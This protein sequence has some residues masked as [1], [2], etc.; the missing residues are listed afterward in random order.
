LRE[1]LR[2]GL[3]A[4]GFE[5]IDGDRWVPLG[6]SPLFNGTTAYSGRVTALAAHPTDP[7]IVYVGGAQGGVWKTSDGGQSWSPLTDGED[8]L[9]IGALALDPSDPDTIYAGTGEPNHSCGSYSGAGILRS[10]DAGT[11]WT[12]IGQTPFADTSIAKIVVHPSIPTILWAANTWGTGGFGCTVQSGSYGVWQSVDGGAN[13]TLVLGAGQTFTDGST[14]ELIISPSDPNRLWAGV[15]RSGLWTS[16]NG[17]TTWTRIAGG[18]PSANIG[19]I[20][21]AVHPANASILYAGFENRS[22]GSYLGTW[23]STD[24]GSSWTAMGEPG[25]VSCMGFDLPDVCGTLCGYTLP[26]ELDPDGDLWLG[27]VGLARSG[28]GAR[29]WQDVCPDDV[30]VDQHAFAVAADGSVWLGNDGGVF[31]TTDDGTTWTNHNDGLSLAQF[32]AGAALHPTLADFA[33]AGTQDNGPV[34]FDA[35]TSW[36]FLLEGD[37]AFSGFDA[38]S[39]DTTWYA[40]AQRLDIHKTTDGGVTMVPATDGLDDVGTGNAAFIAP[41][42]IC[43]HDSDVLVAG[44]DN[45]WRSDDAAASWSSNSPDPLGPGV[46]ITVA[47]APSDTTCS[48]YFVSTSSDNLWRTTDGGSSWDEISGGAFNRQ[49][50][51]LG[52]DP[53][54]ADVVYAALAGFSGSHLYKS[55]NA[56][57]PAPS[58]TA[59]DTGIPDTPANAVLIDP[60]TP[61]VVYLGTDLGIFRSEDTGGSW[62]LFMTGHPNVAVYDLVADVSTRSIVSFTHGRGAFRLTQGCTAPVFAGVD[63]ATDANACTADGVDVHWTTPSSWGVGTTGG[64]FDVRRYGPGNCFGVFTTVVSGLSGADTTF[65]DSTAVPGEAYTYSVVARNDCVTSLASRGTSTCSAS[66]SDL[67]DTIPCPAVGATLTAARTPGSVTVQWQGV[68]CADLDTYEVYG[69]ADFSATFPDTWTLL[70]STPATDHTE[71]LATANRGYRVV[72]TDACGN[73][74]AD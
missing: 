41:F 9:A 56:L 52:V 14:L 64:T 3:L 58:W 26:L 28:D 49:V 60:E 62:A 23:E 70:D 36:T 19:R 63:S 67:E 47:F 55:T 71:S 15:S 8:S 65:H 10:T 20:D 18:L 21:L 53:T 66:V 38:S 16:S 32:Y 34:L 69:T 24:G 48:T 17:G 5:S 44:A 35:S 50:N 25:P 1:N 51:D 29:T 68:A 33:V 13:W 61:G 46:A 40:S 57:D 4:G 27:G 73:R 30:H 37:G 43:P 39:P 7:Q 74:S 11:S 72:S 45:V 6:P 31:R 22:N 12:L 2:N 54:D 59:S 42:A